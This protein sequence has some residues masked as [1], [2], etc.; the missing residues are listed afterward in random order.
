MRI[1]YGVMAMPDKF[2]REI[3]EILAKLDDDLPADDHAYGLS[4]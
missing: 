1:A 2:E 3:E 4:S